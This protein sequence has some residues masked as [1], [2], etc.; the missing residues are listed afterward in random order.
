[1][2][3]YCVGVGPGNPELLTKQACDIIDRVDVVFSGKYAKG[4]YRMAETTISNDLKNKKIIE[5]EFGGF[6]KRKVSQESYWKD[7]ADYFY[8]VLQENGGEG[9]I[10]TPGDPGIFSAFHIMKDSLE[11]LGVETEIINGI[12]APCAIAK[13]LDEPL[14][15]RDDTLIVTSGIYVDDMN[16]KKYKMLLEF[17]STVIFMKGQQ[18]L[19]KLAR[20]DV[21]VANIQAAYVRNAG[22]KNE[23]VYKG[24]LK[25][26]FDLYKLNVMEY[27]RLGSVVVRKSWQRLL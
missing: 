6:R 10:I 26:I 8:D 5:Y 11:K 14:L 27:W 20:R 15:M 22:M 7:T 13:A 25:E 2:K 18:G 24:T 3:L 21:D 12:T 16:L 9:M 23:Y 17:G 19:K 1:M 4:G